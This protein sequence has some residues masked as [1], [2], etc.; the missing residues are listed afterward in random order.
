MDKDFNNLG[1]WLRQKLT[2]RNLSVEDLARLCK[3]RLSRR[4]IYMWI[5]DTARPSAQSITRVCHALTDV[6]VV[7]AKGNVTKVEITTAEAFGQYSERKIGR[8]AGLGTTRS[9]SARAR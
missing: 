6:P 5:E 3:P 8:P 4:A 1:V 7:D 2:E 9:V